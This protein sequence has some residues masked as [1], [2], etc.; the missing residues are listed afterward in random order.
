MSVLT[1]GGNAALVDGTVAMAVAVRGVE[2]D[3]SALLLGG[4]GKVRT[5]ADLV[6]YNNPA[7]DGVYDAGKNPGAVPDDRFYSGLV[8]GF[9]EW[10]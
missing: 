3:V 1:K 10:L 4:S 5:D 6:F 9:A 7:Q 8:Q 2:A